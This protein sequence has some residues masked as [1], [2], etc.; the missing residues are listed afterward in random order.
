MIFRDSIHWPGQPDLSDGPRCPLHFCLREPHRHLFK[1][2]QRIILLSSTLKV[3]FINIWLLFNLL[4]PFTIV[5]LHSFIQYQRS[6]MSKVGSPVKHKKVPGRIPWPDAH[7][8]AVIGLF[9]VKVTFASFE[10]EL[11]VK[12]VV[13]LLGLLFMAS[14]W[15]YGLLHLR[16]TTA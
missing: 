6:S 12:V 11:F 15:I 16:N 8:K 5:L 9:T 4:F 1:G 13:P 2:H 14:Y 10:G 3:T 7:T